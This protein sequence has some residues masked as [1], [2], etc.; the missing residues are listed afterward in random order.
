MRIVTLVDNVVNGG[1]LQAE[2]GLCLYIETDGKKIL[3][4]TG[5]SGLFLKNAKKLG[6]EI[7]DIDYVVLSH[8][9]YD[10]T[11]GLTTF[12]KSNSKAKV[13]AKRGL[14]DPRYRENNRFIGTKI[15]ES[16]V[17]SRLVYVDTV[18]EI[19][20]GVFLM[21]NIPLLHPIDTHFTGMYR[22]VNGQLAA[23]EFDD[24]L[25]L[26][27]KQNDKINILTACSHRGITNICASATSYFK[28]PIGHILGGF[29][30]KACTTEQYVHITHYLR[31]LVPSSVGVCHCTG[32]ERFADMYHECE[33]HLYYN[34][35]GTEMVL[36]CD[37]FK[38]QLL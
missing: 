27:L 38:K 2:H 19:V 20:K 3:F 34:Y 37:T 9:H 17:G 8:G 24:E 30:M 10:H 28:L 7:A 31:M 21:P 29:H 25:F 35:T 16:V 1:C 26:V 13:F 11:G 22:K 14:F 33:A 12:L 36:T 5:Q 15:K 18:E 6:I 32:L 4:D 23:D